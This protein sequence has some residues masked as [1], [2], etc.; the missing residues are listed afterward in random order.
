MFSAS[1]AVRKF[2]RSSLK[3]PPSFFRPALLLLLVLADLGQ[4]PVH[5]LARE[6]DGRVQGERA[7]QRHLDPPEKHQ[8]ALRLHAFPRTVYHPFVRPRRKRLYPRL[9][10]VQGVERYK[11]R[12]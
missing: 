2:E 4:H 11:L 10:H 9:D 3:L 5:G 6:E 12:I 8:R 7:Q 1:E